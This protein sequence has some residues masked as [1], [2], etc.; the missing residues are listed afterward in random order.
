MEETKCL[1]CGIMF[2]PNRYNQY[3]HS[4]DCQIRKNNSISRNRRISRKEINDS[5]D[6]NNKILHSILSD[7]ETM[8]VSR[9]LLEL[10][11]YNFNY[12]THRTRIDGLIFN[13]VFDVGICLMQDNGYLIRNIN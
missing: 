12:I 11:E 8:T 9:G 5:L 13:V 4:R 7:K 2:T 6:K 3:Y 10:Q 1:N